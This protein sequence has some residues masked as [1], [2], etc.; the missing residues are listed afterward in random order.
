MKNYPIENQVCTLEQAKRLK[1]L[2]GDHAPGSLWWWRQS[3]TEGWKVYFNTIVFPGEALRAYTGDEL[4][5]LLPVCLNL[6]D[7]QKYIYDSTKHAYDGSFLIGYKG[8]DNQLHDCEYN[9]CTEEGL[10]TIRL[11][12]LRSKQYEAH[13]KAD[14]AIKL[15]DQKIIKPEDFKY[16]E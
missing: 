6:L 9:L 4:G 2:L 5:A 14:L 8:E 15:L 1:E 11:Y 3:P 16:S 10:E 7:G 13:A 12:L